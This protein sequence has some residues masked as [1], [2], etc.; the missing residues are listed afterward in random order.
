MVSLVFNIPLSFFA[1]KMSACIFPGPPVY[2]NDYSEF[3]SSNLPP[4]VIL[5]FEIHPRPQNPKTPKPQN[6]KTPAT[7]VNNQGEYI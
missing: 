2:S 5:Y 6:P 3:L 7:V 4:L 1:R